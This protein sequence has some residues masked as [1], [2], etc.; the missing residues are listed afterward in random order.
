MCNDVLVEQARQIDPLPP[1]KTQELN[2]DPNSIHV[3][4]DVSA[5]SYS[6]VLL[7][8]LVFLAVEMRC[9]RWVSLGSLRSDL[10]DK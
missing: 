10:C 3:R 1:A 5:S 9:H 6:I 8:G 4:N 7:G 2:H